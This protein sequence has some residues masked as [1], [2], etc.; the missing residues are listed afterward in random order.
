VADFNALGRDWRGPG[1]EILQIEAGASVTATLK[2]AW[3]ATSDSFNF[4]DALISTSALAV[5]LSGITQGHGWSVT[6]KGRATTL[7]GS[8]FNDTLTGGIGNDTLIGGDGADTLIGGK[9]A[10]ILTGGLGADSFRLNGLKGATTAHH[11]T[12]FVSGQDRIELNGAVF[13]AL[14]LGQL[15]ADQFIQ[16]TAAQ[17]ASQHLIYD[18]NNSQLFYDVDGSGKKA[19]V[20]IGVMEGHPALLAQDLWVV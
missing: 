15:S 18:I 1:A 5:D 4:G 9:L 12:D 10:D 17:T 8:Q 6:N 7:T 16:S 3:S 19:A 11:I 14:G 2:S 20:L 13:K